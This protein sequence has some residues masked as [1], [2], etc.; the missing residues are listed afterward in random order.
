MSD[1]TA[2][3]CDLP[4]ESETKQVVISKRFK[5]ADGNPM[6]WTLRALSFADVTQIERQS[7]VRDVKTGAQV[8]DSVAYQTKLMAASVVVPN[9][10]NAQLQDH[11]GVKSPEALLGKLLKPAEAIQLRSEVQKLMGDETLEEALEEAKN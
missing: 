10:L 9:L 6:P 8:L 2:Y 4:L 7:T 5:D 1:L 11:F 3:L